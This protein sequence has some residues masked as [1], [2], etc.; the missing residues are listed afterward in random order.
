MGVPSSGLLLL[1]VAAVVV[2]LVFLEGRRQARLYGKP[3]GRWSWRTWWT[4]RRV[5]C[6]RVRGR[7]DR[8]ADVGDALTPLLAISSWPLAL[9]PEFPSTS[10][11]RRVPHPED[12]KCGCTV[13]GVLAVLGA[14]LLW[15][16]RTAAGTVAA[17]VAGALLLLT[18]AAPAFPAAPPCLWFALAKVPGRVTSAVFLSLTFFLVLAP[19]GSR[20]E[21]NYECA[22]ELD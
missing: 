16:H 12:W 18:A 2:L 6:D 13:G 5:G 3:S 8:T 4:W 21:R 11:I 14:L 9:W 15:R 7:R 19:I 1:A 17:A 10:R 20:L 22:F